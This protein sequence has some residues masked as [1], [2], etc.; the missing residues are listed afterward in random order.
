MAEDCEV[1]VKELETNFGPYNIIGE[2]ENDLMGHMIG[3]NQHI[4]C[5]ICYNLSN[6]WA[7]GMI[8]FQCSPTQL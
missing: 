5:L 4:S 8:T 7:S 1:F 3:D 2:I 6:D